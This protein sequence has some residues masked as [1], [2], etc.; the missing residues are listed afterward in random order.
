[1]MK[2]RLMAIFIGLIMIFSVAGFALMSI[3]W[4]NSGNTP[5]NVPSIVH[6]A[7]TNEQLISLFRS[8][9]TLMQYHYP[10]NCSSCSE[11]TSALEDFVSNMNESVLLEEFPIESNGTALLRM[12]SSSGEISDLSGDKMNQ[13]MLLDTFCSI[14]YVQTQECL[15][16]NI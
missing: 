6:T 14:S 5:V 11:V 8:G 2:E 16:R 15:L 3:R 13:T 9:K 1:M 4:D 10:V 12:V 7:L